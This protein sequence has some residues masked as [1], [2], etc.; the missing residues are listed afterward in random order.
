MPNRL[1]SHSNE[2]VAFA[3]RATDGFDV[4]AVDRST[5]RFLPAGAD[6]DTTREQAVDG[7]ARLDIVFYFKA[8]QTGITCA[9]SSAALVGATI[10]GERFQGTD[11]IDVLGCWSA[12]RVQWSS[13]NICQRVATGLVRA[14]RD[15]RA[16]ADARQALRPRP[17]LAL[18][19]AL[20]R[21]EGEPANQ[22]DPGGQIGSSDRAMAQPLN[23]PS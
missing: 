19:V 14:L 1:N 13:G 8:R 11:S 21:R 10:E 12:E 17:G 15:R 16:A 23:P 9:D 3:V 18:R 7:E 6:A 2:L 4:M 5:V 22:D 20:H